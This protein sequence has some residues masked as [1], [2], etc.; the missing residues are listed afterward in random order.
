[1]IPTLRFP[2]GHRFAFGAGAAL[3]FATTAL[4]DVTL[5]PLF[6]DG[7]VLQ[8]DK[9]L[10]VWGRSAAGEKIEVRFHN[11]IVTTAAD[12]DGRWRVVLKP[13]RT[14]TQPAELT[15][16]GKN[17]LRVTNVLVGEVWLCS[18]QSNM[19]WLL[20]GADDA[21][22]EIARPANPLL[23]Q[24]TV[25]R[26]AARTPAEDCVGTWMAA[27]PETSARF[28]AVAYHFGWKIQHETGVP[29]GVINASWG[30]TPIEFWLSEP[31]V[32]RDP[33]LHAAQQRA[34]VREPQFAAEL[35]AFGESGRAWAEKFQRSD[36]VSDSTEIAKFTGTPVAGAEGWTR[37][38]LPEGL[39][40]AALPK[41]G[42]IWLRR[43]VRVPERTETIG[44]ER[45]FLVSFGSFAGFDHVYWNGTKIGES[46][47]QKLP[48]GG[49]RYA[50][51]PAL[52]R[53]GADA[54]V[55]IRIFN[56][57]DTGFALTVP[58]G[59]AFLADSADLRGEWQVTTE[60]ALPPLPPGALAAYPRHPPLAPT[61]ASRMFNGLIAPLAGSA[62]RGFIWYQ[63]ESNT[64]RA[65]QYA[66]TFPLMIRDWREHWGAG[67]LPFYFC[68]L[69]NANAKHAQPRESG[70]AEL[71]EA[72]SRTLALPNT[73][74]A[75]LIDVGEED[76]L[77]PRN[78]RD[79]GERLARIALARDYRKTVAE[80]G[81][82]FAAAAIEGARARVR[83]RSTDGGLVARPLPDTYRPRSTLPRTVPFHRHS[84]GGTVEGFAICGADRRW[85]WADTA[86]IEG[87]TV[88]VSSREVSAPVAVRYA[89]ADHPTCNLA[90][91]A[92]LPAAP[93]RTDAFPLSTAEARF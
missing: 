63:G 89:W 19:E 18:G 40:K 31:A 35:R 26:S 27:G 53:P 23:R 91:G 11:Q 41:S 36:R 92:G 90:N 58:S 49:R 45:G 52:L 67:D 42:A 85:V 73:G 9:P 10:P 82:V 84:T 32:A 50:V 69:A 61:I 15:V 34:L 4:A 29:V 80:S 44:L 48:P 66:T 12:A 22:A 64:G 25:K 2:P 3:V 70:W 37:V 55:A 54:T 74:Q 60:F 59:A 30:G 56:P 57:L 13:E 39:E 51:P 43:T 20:S 93:F 79:V 88:I 24:F 7:A 38:V 8:R 77:H 75:V 28:S 81:P 76:D 83:F 68:Q 47:W 78:K 46:S 33:E 86:R 6:R 87:D 72:Q 62:L 5:A 65:V 17:M 1:M 21:A 14:A 16:T 71:R